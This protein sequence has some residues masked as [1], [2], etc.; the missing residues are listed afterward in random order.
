MEEV[1][2]KVCGVFSAVV[3]GVTSAPSS[4][5]MLWRCC[6][7]WRRWFSSQS[8]SCWSHRSGGGGGGGD[9]GGGGGGGGGGRGGGGL[10]WLPKV[11]SK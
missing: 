7:A 11:I 2:G 10:L 8:L 4:W 1:F 9:G 6:C 5:G 3:S